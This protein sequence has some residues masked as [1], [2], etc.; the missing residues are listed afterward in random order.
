MDFRLLGPVELW[1]R[2]RPVDIGHAKQ[3]TVLAVL[4]V[5][6]G[7]PV[8]ADKL[9]DRVWDHTPPGSALGVLYGYVTR[10]RR[11]LSEAGTALPRTAGGYLVDVDPDRVDLH[12]FRA[13]LRAA[14]TG[15]EPVPALLDQALGLWGGTPLADLSGQWVA[16]TRRLLEEQR[17]SAIVARNEACLRDGRLADLVPALYEQVTAYPTDER[18]VGQLMLALSRTGR[19]PAALDEYR[20]ACRRLRDELGCEPGRALREIH[21]AVLNDGS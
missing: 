10:L 3:R 17:L 9:I 15:P 14:G 2:G 20:S 18:L 21:H 6:A 7:R 11:S 16:S 13:L 1:Y 19:A 12:R 8:S 4:L 5:E